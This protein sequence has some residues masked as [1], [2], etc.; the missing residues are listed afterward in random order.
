MVSA[1]NRI[2]LSRSASVRQGARKI[3]AQF[4]QVLGPKHL[5]FVIKELRQ[6][7]L[8]GFQVIFYLLY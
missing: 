7:L 2:L 3:M 8:K 1:L 5:P 6:T 4:M